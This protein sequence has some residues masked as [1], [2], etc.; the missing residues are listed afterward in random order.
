[1]KS[2]GTVLWRPKAAKVFFH[3]PKFEIFRLKILNAG[4]NTGLR[5]ISRVDE[6]FFR[7]LGLIP[8][9]PRKGVEQNLGTYWHRQDRWRVGKHAGAR[10]FTPLSNGDQQQVAIATQ[11]L[12]N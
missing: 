11:W 2:P 4:Q 5:R 7:A 10:L 9:N 1:M 3:N 6:T 12:P 8:L